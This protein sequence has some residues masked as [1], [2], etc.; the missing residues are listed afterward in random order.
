MSQDLYDLLGVSRDADAETIKKAYRRMARR[1][2]PDV[3]P[4]P[5]TQE[6]FKEVSRA[7]EVLSDPQ[8]R[9][10]YDRGGDPFGGAGGFGQGAGF[11]FTDIM[12][13]FFGGAAASAG[14]GPR[15]RVRRGQDALVRVEVDLIHPA[16]QV[17][18][19]PALVGAKTRRGPKVDDRIRPGAEQGALVGGR[20]IAR[21]PARRAP[22]GRPLGLGHHH[23]GGEVLVLAPQAVGHPAP[24]AGMPHE[25]PPG[26]HLIMG[27]GVDDAVD[28]ARADQGDLVRV[29]KAADKAN[30]VAAR[31]FD[32][33]RGAGVPEGSKSLAI[34]V[35]LQPGE[36]SYD[37][38][39][40]KA[41]AEKVV[42]AA[43]KLGAELR[44]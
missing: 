3:N 41:I 27:R 39:A 15:P 40:L 28:P 2:H 36:K 8:K 30:I 14:R 12:D 29:V 23:E 26:V 33:F 32:D 21:P 17:E 7:Y 31:L 6:Q 20:Q 35:T 24:Q 22:F 34:E 4:D 43:A 42:A 38:A 5:E 16:E 25:D 9:A 44:G 11:S 37:E 1:L 10:A 18:G 13:A 19:R